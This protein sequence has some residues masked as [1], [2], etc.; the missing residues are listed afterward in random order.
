MG[1]TAGLKLALKDLI[2]NN[3][4]ELVEGLVHQGVNREIAQITT[5]T[6][7]PPIGYY[8]IMIDVSLDREQSRPVSARTTAHP[9]REVIYTA[10]VWI[11]D[12]AQVE[13]D[14]EQQ[15]VYETMHLD[16]DRFVD[17]VAY[18]IEQQTWI[19]TTPKVKL[20]RARGS[21]AGA[22]GDREV[23]REN[24]SATWEN[25][26]G[27]NVASLLSRLTFRLVDECPDDSALY[28]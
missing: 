1:N 8:F 16:F 7:S 17:R 15:S 13:L 4:N 19:G 26:E 22:D 28:A 27:D 20:A 24:L 21:G 9:S 18:L 2:Q 6:L 14:D 23:Q 10:Q 12:V 3:N 11:G 25:N 5:S